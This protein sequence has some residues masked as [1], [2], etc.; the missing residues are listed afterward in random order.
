MLFIYFNLII[1]LSEYT[2]FYCLRICLNLVLVI[3][4]FFYYKQWI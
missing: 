3:S 4:N 1:S 2:P